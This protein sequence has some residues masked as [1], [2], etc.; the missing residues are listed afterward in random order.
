V[1]PGEFKI[2]VGSNSE[3]LIESKLEVQP[4]K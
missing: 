3:E 4:T 2:M 1:E